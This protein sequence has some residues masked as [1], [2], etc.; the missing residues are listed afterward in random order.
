VLLRFSILIAL[1]LAAPRWN[2]PSS[3]AAP[4]P[5]ADETGTVTCSFS[6]PAY[7][8]NCKQ[9]ERIPKDGSAKAV[10]QD[11]LDCLNNVRC[12]KTYCNAT[13]IRSGWKLE[14]AE[15]NPPKK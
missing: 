1:A 13:Q 10:C 4:A 14:S 6:H 8:G 7:S 15:E 11:I 9:T 12:T 5:A 3:G 2:E